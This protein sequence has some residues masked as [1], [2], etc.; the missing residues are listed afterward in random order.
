MRDMG[1]MI[2]WFSR[3][4]RDEHARDRSSRRRLRRYARGDGLL[5]P[6]AR[7]P[8]GACAART[9]EQDRWQPPYD[10]LRHYFFDMGNDSLFA[11]F[12]YPRGLPRQQRDHVGGLQH[13]AFHVPAERFDAMVEHV[14]SCGIRVVGPVPLGG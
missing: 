13:V 14:R 2:M 3:G 4:G 8:P 7:L 6:R 11:V 1:R 5:Y 12:E 9:Y 10:T